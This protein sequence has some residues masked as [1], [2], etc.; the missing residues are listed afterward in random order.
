MATKM[1]RVVALF[2]AFSMVIGMSAN[3]LATSGLPVCDSDIHV[4]TI[5]CYE[6]KCGK[7]EQTLDLI[8]E[9]EE[10]IHTEE[11]HVHSAECQEICDQPVCEA[12]EHIHTEECHVHSAECQKICEQVACELEHTHVGDCYIPHV[13]TIEC[14]NLEMLKCIIPAHTHN[15]RCSTVWNGDMLNANVTAG[16]GAYTFMSV[17]RNPAYVYEMSN[18]MVTLDGAS[19]DIPQTLILVDADNNYTWMPNGMY[20]FGSSNYEV[21]YCCDAVTGYKDGIYYK[22]MNLEDSTYY[23]ETEAAH[24]RAIVTNS[25]PYVSLEQMKSNLAAE[26]FVDAEK[27][28]RAEIITAVQ[29]AIWYFANQEAFVYGRTFDIPSNSQWGTVM[30]DYTNEL[31]DAEGNVWWPEKKRDFAVNEEVGGRINALIEHLKAQTAV[32]ADK[33]QIVISSLEIVD[34]TPVMEKNGVYTV[35]VR[36]ALNNSGSS[37]RDNIS[38]KAYVGDQCVDTVSVNY[39][40]DVYTMVVEAAAGQTI[41][42]EVSGTQIMPQGVYFYEPVGGRGISQ[43]LVGVAAGATDVYAEAEITMNTADIFTGTLNLQKVDE[44]GS[45][46][47]GASFALYYQFENEFLLVDTYTVDANGQLSVSGLMPGSYKLVETVVP[48]GYQACEDAVYFSINAGGILEGTNVNNGV[49]TVVNKLPDYKVIYQYIGNVPGN[50]PAVPSE[51]VYKAGDA[52]VIA[53]DPAAS[54]Y[55][56]SGWTVSDDL[57]NGMPARNVV[58]TGYWMPVKNEKDAPIGIKTDKLT[59][60]DNYEYEVTIAVPGNGDASHDEVIIMMDGSY[61]GDEEWG[62]ARE[63][64]LAVGET[65]LDGTGRTRLTIMAFGMADNMVVEHVT[66]MKQLEEYLSGAKPGSLLYGRSSTNCEAGFTG[67]AEYIMADA[68]LN[69]ACVIY[70]TDGRVNTDETPR[71]FDTNWKTWTKFGALPVAQETLGG[72]LSNGINLP[73]AFYTVFGNRFNGMTNAEILNNA[74]G[75][76]VTNEEFLAFADQV[77]ADVYAYS[78]LAS[79]GMYPISVVETA[80]VKYDKEQGTYIQDLFYYTTYK[81]NYVTYPDGTARAVRAGT[82]LAAVVSQLHM[83]DTDGK[84]DWMDPASGGVAGNNVTFTQIS[85]L[86]NFE[87]LFAAGLAKLSR[88]GHTNVTV[89]D[90]MSKWVN[91]DPA[92]SNLRIVDDTTGETIWTYTDGWKIAENRPTSKNPPVAVEVVPASDYTAGGADVVGNTSGDIYKLTW[93]VKDDSLLRTDSYSLRYTV[94]VDTEENGFVSGAAYPANGNTNVTFINENGQPDGNTIKVPNVTAHLPEPDPTYTVT[95]R[96]VDETGKEIKAAVVS[97]LMS[98]GS[99]YDVTA[100]TVIN[101]DGYTRWNTIGSVSGIL[102]SNVTVTVVYT[103]NSVPPAIAGPIVPSGNKPTTTPT[104]TLPTEQIPL[105]DIPGVFS[106]DHYAYIIGYPDGLVHPEGNITRAEVATIFFRLLSD[107]VRDSNLTAE[108]DFSDVNPGM[109]F[110][111]AVST[112]CAMDIVTGYEDG[113][114]RPNENIT[115]AEFAAIAARFDPFGST[116]SVDFSDIS[117]HWAEEL[118]CIAANNGWVKGYEDG[119]FRPDRLITRAEAMT[120]INRVLHRIPETPDDLL[121]YMVIWPDNMD[122]TKWYYLAVQEATNSHHYQRKPSE[123][124]YWTELREVRDW[125]VYEK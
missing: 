99:V 58:V 53:P 61:S 56:F 48:Q 104:V 13:H 94:T 72:T 112:L 33:N 95:V 98:A 37:T 44:Y 125:T 118:I 102:N 110:N 114:F 27:L 50:V 79:G 111:H 29:S 25:Y 39:G 23:D 90:Y 73:R 78:G 54:G 82:E 89:T 12:E 55:T 1:K 60:A 84:S 71:A 117:G 81:S 105:A 75:G 122:V 40:T 38:L 30:H 107:E 3:T 5:E 41:K 67:V 34:T 15:E 80:F 6:T 2:L 20:S 119:T 19:F 120:L 63:A 21:M 32:Y 87:A 51:Q 11:C 28:T 66:S 124:E 83:I 74:F 47:N 26:G 18:H 10:H 100:L 113:T 88:T 86:A 123:Y 59:D 103:R 35:A 7:N 76:A 42:A 68:N 85:D 109:W 108:N 92:S 97:G 91:F 93:N 4:H 62:N 16:T 49:L 9:A 96:Y 77:W 115:R 31:R 24:I 116:D 14:C 17:Y 70:I 46:L 69:E 121:D 43:S 52:V 8:C 45:H 106:P 64:I 36:V 22:R 57:T 101:I 65:V